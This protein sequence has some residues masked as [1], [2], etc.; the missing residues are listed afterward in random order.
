MARNDYR[1]LKAAIILK[2]TN[3]R[4]W[5]Q[6]NGFPASS[7][8]GAASGKRAGVEAVKIKRQLEDFAYGR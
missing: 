6:D 8:Y 2:G 7:V 1:A 4:R 3:L 5:A